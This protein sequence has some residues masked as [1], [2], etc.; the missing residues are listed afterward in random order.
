MTCYLL[1]SLFKKVTF[2][3]LDGLNRIK[4]KQFLKALLYTFNKHFFLLFNP[5]NFD[6][7]H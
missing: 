3:N 2:A 6:F 7:F 1:K 5:I 4:L